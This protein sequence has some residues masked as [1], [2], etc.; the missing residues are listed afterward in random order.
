MVFKSF[1]IEKG[2]EQD[3]PISTHCTSKFIILK[4]QTFDFPNFLD[5]IRKDKK[6]EA[7]T[8]ATHHR[9]LMG[10]HELMSIINTMDT[11]WDKTCAKVLG[12]ANKSI[13][14][15]TRL[16]LLDLI[17]HDTMLTSV[18]H[19]KSV[20]LV[21]DLRLDEAQIKEFKMATAKRA[22][23]EKGFYRSVERGTAIKAER[24]RPKQE[25]VKKDKLYPI[26]IIDRDKC[27]NKV[28]IHYTGYSSEFDEWRDATEVSNGEQSR[29]FGRLT[30]RFEPSVNSAR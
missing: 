17:Q 2:E 6:E 22:R 10:K 13:E 16:E 21:S 28:K 18:K 7:D 8:S 11:E 4:S 27:S 29:K 19:V 3:V 26:E 5:Q 25:K 14:E 20:N 12:G 1:Y 15:I 24:I 9:L 23:H 30:Q